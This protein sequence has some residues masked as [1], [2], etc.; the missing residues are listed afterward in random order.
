MKF[1][2]S[3]IV[4][5]HMSFLARVKSALFTGSRYVQMHK[6]A[7]IY[8]MYINSQFTD[9]DISYCTGNTGKSPVCVGFTVHS[10]LLLTHQGCRSVHRVSS[11]FTFGR[12]VTVHTQLFHRDF[13]VVHKHTIYK[14]N[15]KLLITAITE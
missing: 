10:S 8:T 1:T 6:C 5:L 2:D 15:W 4:I 3:D 11:G 12:C 7:T 13:S 9:S 14:H